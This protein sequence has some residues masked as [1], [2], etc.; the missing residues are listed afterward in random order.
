MRFIC[1]LYKSGFVFN[2]PL[3]LWSKGHGLA[4]GQTQLGSV[5]K[6]H[7]TL[8]IPVDFRMPGFPVHHQLPEFTQTHVHWV[9]NAIQ[10]SH[11]L[12]PP[13]PPAFNLSYHQDLFQWVSSSHQVPKVGFVFSSPLLL[14]KEETEEQAPSWKQDSILG[15]TVDFE[16]SMHGNDIST[17]KPDLPHPPPPP[18]E[19]PQGLYLNSVT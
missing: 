11:H 15:R 6:S 16:P 4:L 3:L 18:M 7:P 13:F 1:N 19:K 8:C 2:S 12:S 17:G 14:L 9:D 5:I 10:P